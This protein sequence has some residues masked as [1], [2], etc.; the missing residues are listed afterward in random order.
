MNANK[1]HLAILTCIGLGI[2]AVD[3]GAVPVRRGQAANDWPQ[4]RGPDRDGSSQETG[5]L[6]TWPRKGPPLLWEK[7]VG[8]GYSGPVVVGDRV[9]VFYR[10]GDQDV[11]ECLS[12]AKG[13]PRW[14]FPYKTTY[15]DS[16]GKGD[17]PR[18]TPVVSGNRVYT[19]GAQGKL[20][21]LNLDSGKKVWSRSI[22]ED[23]GVRQN[24]FGVGTTP[25]ILGKVLLVNVGGKQAGIVAFSTDTGKEVWKAT[26]DAASYSSPVAATIDG[27]RHAIFFTREGIVSLDPRK[28]TIR[29]RKRWRARY[30]ASVNAATPVVVGKLLFISA[31]YETGAI[32][33]RL[34]KDGAEEIW[35]GDKA[36]SNHYETS[37]HHKGFLYGFDGR[38]ESGAR[39]R[40]V[41]L[42]TGKVRWTKED[43][44]CGSMILA[45]GKL[46]I[47]TEGGDLVLVE[48]SPTEYREKARAL[49]LMKPARAPMALANGRLYLRDD[50]NV[51]CLDLK[52]K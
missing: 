8:P 38:Q 41:E 40:C 42:K 16:M 28:G 27:V 3:T 25:L 13:K 14:K 50:K 51:R 2:L 9:I 19:L 32:V 24:Y 47:L 15:E 36:L 29:F 21:C 12:A 10:D 18:S 30:D 17:G 23:Y 22:N 44:G 35:S 34:K 26:G 39:L 37:I 49:R 46:I 6:N 7:K 48:A 4:F 1:R 43:F 52:K 33:L 20:H 45:E 11:V 5:L 31:S